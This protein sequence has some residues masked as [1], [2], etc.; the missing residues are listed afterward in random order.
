MSTDTT[1]PPLD[2]LAYEAWLDQLIPCSEGAQLR[3][4]SEAT[5]KRHARA[6]GQLVQVG[7]RAIRIRRREA[8]ML[9]DR[10]RNHRRRG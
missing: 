4:V 6:T 2:P 7:E 10:R 5:L 8:M 9:P 3:H 1:I